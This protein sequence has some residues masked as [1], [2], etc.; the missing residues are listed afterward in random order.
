MELQVPWSLALLAPAALLA[1]LLLA[2]LP[3]C[4]ARARLSAVDRTTDYPP[5][6]F[7]PLCSCSKSV[8]DLGIVW[9]R[10]VPLPRAPP[11]LNASKVFMLHLDNNGLRSLDAHFLTGTGRQ[12]IQI[13]GLKI[14]RN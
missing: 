10:D 12:K 4:E 9:C 3:G 13:N 11:P 5:C 8:P 6:F 7:N 2:G 14:Q 1:S